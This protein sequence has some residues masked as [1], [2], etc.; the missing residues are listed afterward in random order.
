MLT[1]VKI[2]AAKPSTRPLKLSDGGG[3]HLLI[4][5]HGSRLWR[6]NYRFGGKQ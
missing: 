6:A 5:P 1:D 3:L 4:Q 2:R